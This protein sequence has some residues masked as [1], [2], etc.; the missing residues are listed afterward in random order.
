VR[1]L[2]DLIGIYMIVL[3]ARAVTSWFPP[4]Q[5]GTPFASVISILR[6]LTEPVL[7]PFR[8][9]IPPVGMFDIS[10]IVVFILFSILYN[11]T[12]P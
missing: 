2:H 4:P 8:R 11:L 6:D 1:I 9:I 5:S 7:A 12:S 3:F 10:Y